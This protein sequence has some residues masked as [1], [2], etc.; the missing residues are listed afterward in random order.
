MPS[1]FI[2]SLN[3]TSS[4][5]ILFSKNELN[6]FSPMVLTLKTALEISDRITASV[7]MQC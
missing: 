7:A 4:L 5:V 1:F 6:S 2:G 3:F